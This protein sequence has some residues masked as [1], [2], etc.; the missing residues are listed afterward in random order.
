MVY[1]DGFDPFDTAPCDNGLPSD[2]GVGM[3]YAAALDLCRTAGETGV[4]WGVISAD[5][6]LPSGLGTP[7]AAAAPGQPS[8][9]HVAFQP[10]LDTSTSSIAPADWLAANGG[11]FPVAPGCPAAVGAIAHNPV[12]LTLGIRVPGNARS[13]S[14]QVHFLA[15]DFPEWVCSPYNDMFVALLESSFAGAPPNPADRNLARYTT[16][17]ATTYPL[18]VNLA[19]GDTGLFRQCRN[20]PTGCAGGIP[21][22]TSSCLGIGGLQ[23]TGMDLS[24]SDACSPTS[25]V[26]GASDWLGV[27]GNVV[28]GETIRLRLALWDTGDPLSDSVVLLDGF[29]WSRATATPGVF[30]P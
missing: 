6:T 14:F 13:F 30:V 1:A 16:P 10:G 12:M 29:A 28:P 9:P 21:G 7:A 17:Q 8:P 11:V 24:I 26:G 27:R 23:G 19:W 4:A 22:T 2:S 3:Q 15:A 25:M 18:G 20:G 5:L